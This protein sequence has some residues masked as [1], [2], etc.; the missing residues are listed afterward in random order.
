VSDRAVGVTSGAEPE[1]IWVMAVAIA[2]FG[3]VQVL[4]AR[5]R[6]PEAIGVER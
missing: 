6:R 4:R 1:L 2:L 3:C 5:R